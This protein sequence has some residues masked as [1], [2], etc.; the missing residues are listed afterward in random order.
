MYYYKIIIKLL[1]NFLPADQLSPFSKGSFRLLRVKV[2]NSFIQQMS[3]VTII[4]SHFV[5]V[6]SAILTGSKTCSIGRN[7]CLVLYIQPQI[8]HCFYIS[9]RLRG[10][11]EGRGAKTERDRR[12]EDKNKAVSSRSD[13]SV[14]LMNSLQLLLSA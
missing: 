9:C 10:H 4:M 14:P 7:T 11:C 6:A 13:M 12:W 3:P 2:I 8:V 5:S 1:F